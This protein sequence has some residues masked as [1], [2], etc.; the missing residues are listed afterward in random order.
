MGQQTQKKKKKKIND[1]TS[2]G[3]NKYP[4]TAGEELITACVS[5]M[6]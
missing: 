2:F 4:R 5:G 6:L 3:I 1:C